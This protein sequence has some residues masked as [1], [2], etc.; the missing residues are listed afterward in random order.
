MFRHA[1]GRLRRLLSDVALGGRAVARLPGHLVADVPEQMTGCPDAE[2]EGDENPPH[3]RQKI[4]PS[5]TV[6]APVERAPAAGLRG[7]HA[8]V[9]LLI[10]G[11]SGG[12]LG[13][14]LQRDGVEVLEAPDVA[15]AGED[16]VE[17]IAA[18]LRAFEGLLSVNPVDGVALVGSSGPVVA[19]L[20]VATR[21]RV[22]VAAIE[23][24]AAPE[25]GAAGEMNRR[26][27]GRLADAIIPD[28]PSA[29]AAW[30]RAS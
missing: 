25:E 1:L 4:Y 20:L 8:A 18:G 7:K 6:G 3:Q 26:L 24:K 29:L 9:R 2:I 12:D 17:Q 21:L 10:V 27:V 14:A 5:D 30:L 15:E 19:A 28:D 11:E 16:Q 23:T 22:R 13:D